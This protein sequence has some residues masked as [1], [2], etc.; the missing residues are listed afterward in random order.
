MGVPLV[1]VGEN[2][3]FPVRI[4][5][6]NLPNIG[7]VSGPPGTPLPPVPASLDTYIP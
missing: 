4:G 2:L 6:T 1:I 7:R 3:P 5:L